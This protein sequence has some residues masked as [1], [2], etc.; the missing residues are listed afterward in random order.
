MSVNEYDVITVGIAT[1]KEIRERMINIATGDY[2]AMSSE[3]K[4]WIDSDSKL[5]KTL[6][7]LLNKSQ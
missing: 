4:I 2:I 6:L 1:Q 7:D 5:G 3:P